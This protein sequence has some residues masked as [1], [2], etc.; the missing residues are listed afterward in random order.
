[1][2]DSPS[3]PL[4]SRALAYAEAGWCVFPCAPR[5]KVPI[6]K[7]GFKDASSD[8]ARVASWWESNADANVAVACGASGLV[9]VD[10]DGEKG[11]GNLRGVLE[12]LDLNEASFV[13]AKTGGGGMHLFFRA[14]PGGPPI[15]CRAGLFGGGVDVKGNGGYVVLPPSV[16]P[17]GAAYEWVL[18]PW[19]EEL[20]EIPPALAQE[21]VAAAGSPR[22]PARAAPAAEGAPGPI[23]EGERDVTLTALAGSLRRHGATE[24]EIL[25]SLRLFNARCKPPHSEAD[26]ERIARSVSRYDPAETAEFNPT[27]AGNAEIFA[28][29]HGGVVRYDQRHKRWLVWNGDIWSSRSDDVLTRFAIECARARL[30]GAAKINDEKKRKRAVNWAF[31]SENEP[32]IRGMLAI[33]QDLPPVADDGSGWDL[34][35]YLLGVDNGVVDLRTGELRPGRRDDGVTRTSAREYDAHAEAPRWERF[36]K[37]VFVDDELIAWM[38]MAVGYSLT[39]DTSEQRFFLCYGGGANGKSVFLNALRHAFGYYAQDVPFTVFEPT[40]AAA[41]AAS[42]ILA[43][44][45]GVRFVT[46]EEVRE[47]SR[48]DEARIKKLTGGGVVMAR[49][50]YGNPFTFQPRLHLW[51]AVNHRPAVRDDT[52]AFWRRA[53]AVPFTQKFDG[54][55]V[56]PY[57]ERTLADEAAGILR[58]AVEGAAAWYKDRLDSGGRLVLEDPPGGADLVREWRRENDPLAEF[59]ATRC[60]LGDQYLVRTGLLYEEYIN[61]CDDEKVPKRERLSSRWFGRKISE[62][63][64]ITAARDNRGNRIYWGI[65]LADERDGDE[66]NGV[67]DF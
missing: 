34:D 33:A 39:G 5:G 47:N 48:F 14:P 38:R 8:A 20:V 40:K 50:L 44:L 35:P 27:D 41:E 57:L 22:R 19:D 1:M 59:I 24:D 2:P 65:G 63:P 31:T 29:R 18:S 25:A 3:S 60:I 36:L 9:V 4:A 16:H 54:D 56:D 42:P 61:W 28:R 43:S 45:D 64:E 17:S 51:F 66:Q 13:R 52:E 55:R 62:K 15:G 49:Y 11:L 10:A 12:S 46:S 53:F 7:S 58:W 30:A 23:R 26:L 67:D 21:I 6:T 37:E 32:R